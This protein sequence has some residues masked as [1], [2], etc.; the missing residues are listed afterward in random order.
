MDL[1]LDTET[2]GF[3]PYGCVDPTDPRQPHCVQLALAH[4]ERSS[5]R[6]VNAAKFLLCPEGPFEIAPGA[7]E[8]HGISAETCRLQD[9]P[10]S[11]GFALFR[12]MSALADR[13]VAHNIDYDWGIL[14][15]LAFRSNV[16]L[17]ALP[18]VPRFCTMR[19]ATPLCKLPPT[20]RMVKAGR[21]SQYKAP[22]LIEA[23]KILVS[24]EGFDKAHDAFADLSAMNAILNALEEISAP[25][26]SRP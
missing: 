25:A 8:V 21:G 7:Q 15:A 14:A 5:G 4:R 13:I 6:I 9:I 12:I 24:P 11:K 22:K 20:E 3:A 1:L 19:A 2:T 16:G 23:Y 18:K 17:E 10:A 26:E